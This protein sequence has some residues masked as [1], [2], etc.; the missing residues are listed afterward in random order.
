[1]LIETC[2]R[3]DRLSKYVYLLGYHDFIQ[4]GNGGKI[5]RLTIYANSK[6][7]LLHKINQ[8][9][10]TKYI[11]FCK[12]NNAE[13]LREC[14]KREKIS[15]IVL[16]SSN[17]NIF[18]KKSILNMIRTNNKIVD[19]WLPFSSS[20]VISK[21]IIW[22]YKWINNILFSSCASKFNEIW[23]PLSKINFLVCH[24]ADEEL[25]TYWILM[26]P[27]VL[28]SNASSNN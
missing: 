2:I 18:R 4:E 23:S 17:I 3:D 27:L 20:Y 10:S 14:I 25:A 8:I 9:K 26:S 24:G 11:I 6:A 13:V 22:G 21:V 28:M 15:A 5:R 12:T 1:M 7:E 19:V 16:D